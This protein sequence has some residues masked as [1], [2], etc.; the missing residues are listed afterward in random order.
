MK[1]LAGLVIVALLAGGLIAVPSAP[2]FASHGDCVDEHEHFLPLGDPGHPG[3]GI[4]FG[5]ELPLIDGF[6]H[7]DFLIASDVFRI[8]AEGVFAELLA[9]LDIAR[10]LPS[11]LPPMEV[12]RQIAIAIA[13]VAA[14]IGLAVVILARLNHLYQTGVASIL[15]ECVGNVHAALEEEVNVLLDERLAQIGTMHDELPLDDT[16]TISETQERNVIASVERNLA[17]A[18]PALARYIIPEDAGG[19]LD[20][21]TVG[22]RDVVHD[23]FAQVE[24]A[25]G[26]APTATAKDYLRQADA[27]LDAGQFK[28]AY[29]NYRRAYQLV[30]Q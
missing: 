16:V 19:F 15:E 24:S 8:S 22:V 7:A 17:S 29:R 23:A 26:V 25:T 21:P 27:A 18:G 11:G 28:T 13:Q 30:V 14:T 20:R 10:A 12:E 2:A 1:R 6:G 9:N 4:P 5:I 3:P